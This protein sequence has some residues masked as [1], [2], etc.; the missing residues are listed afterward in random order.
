MVNK[1]S[2]SIINEKEGIDSKLR[3]I[4]IEP[5]DIDKVFIS[6]MDSDH[7]S[8]LRLVKEAKQVQTSEEEWE[9]CNQFSLRYVNTWTGICDVDTFA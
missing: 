5:E 1:I 9:A 6:Y 8:G 4:G 3:G 7:T 2:T